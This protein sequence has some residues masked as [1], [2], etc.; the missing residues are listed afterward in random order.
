MISSILVKT[1]L[2][3]GNKRGERCETNDECANDL[4][5]KRKNSKDDVHGLCIYTGKNTRTEASIKPNKFYE[6]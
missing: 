4:L 6:N 3:I 2:L 5:C 1:L